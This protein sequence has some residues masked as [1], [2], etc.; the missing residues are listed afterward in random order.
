[1]L[2]SHYQGSYFT[3]TCIE[4]NCADNTYMYEINTRFFRTSRSRRRW[5]CR[6]L[7]SDKPSCPSFV[8][9]V[10][11]CA[12]RRRSS[13]FLSIPF[14]DSMA[15]KCQICYREVHGISTQHRRAPR[16]PS[17]G[18]I[19]DTQNNTTFLS[20]RSLYVFLFSFFALPVEPK[21]LGSNVRKKYQTYWP[22]KS[23]TFFNNLVVLSEFAFSLCAGPNTG[24]KWPTE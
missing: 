12:A 10:A 4:S 20:A 11:L 8:R 21:F 17:R 16:V 15:Y 3:S 23:P 5:L 14:I 18:R 7:F 2:P 13:H 24:R 22:N 19:F 6:R 9:L 1:M